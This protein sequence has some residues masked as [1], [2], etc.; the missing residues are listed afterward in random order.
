MHSYNGH[1]CVDESDMLVWVTALIKL[2][3]DGGLNPYGT[4]ASYLI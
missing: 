1:L 3:K 2:A 4:D